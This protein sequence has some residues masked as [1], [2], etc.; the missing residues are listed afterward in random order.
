MDNLEQTGRHDSDDIQTNPLIS[1]IDSVPSVSVDIVAALVIDL[2]KISARAKGEQAGERV[3]AACERAEDR[4]RRIGFRTDD[5]EGQIYDTNMRVRVV[6]HDGGA[7]PLKIS[8][9]LSP[10]VYY[11]DVLVR[12]AEV[13]TKGS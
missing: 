11:R 2:W 7:E 3:L 9:C 13:I 4:L 1:E 6:E 12:E 5:P 10:A 8:Q